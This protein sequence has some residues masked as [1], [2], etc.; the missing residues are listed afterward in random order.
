MLG[1]FQNSPTLAALVGVCEWSLF[2]KVG[3]EV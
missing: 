2:V 3:L 1:D